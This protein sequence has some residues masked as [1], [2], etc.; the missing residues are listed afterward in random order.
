LDL[1]DEWPG[2][3]AN[4]TEGGDGQRAGEVVGTRKYRHQS[5]NSVPADFSEKQPAFPGY[6]QVRV[7]K[8]AYE[9]G[10]CGLSHGWNFIED[11]ERHQWPIR[12]ELNRFGDP[13][14]SSKRRFGPQPISEGRRRV[15]RTALQVFGGDEVANCR[16]EEAE[17][18]LTSPA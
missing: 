12:R 17:G 5:R 10:H 11:P 18:V 4:F 13:D 7:V 2:V 8:H 15:R 6:M 9:L 16:A 3:G 1:W 14:R